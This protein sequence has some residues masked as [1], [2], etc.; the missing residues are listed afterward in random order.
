MQIVE[1]ITYK[2]V[3][4]ETIIEKWVE[5]LIEKIVEVPVEKIIEVPVI[6]TIEI[7]VFKEVIVEE[8]VFVEARSVSGWFGLEFDRIITSEEDQLR[9]DDVICQEEDASINQVWVVI[10]YVF[11][12][13][14]EDVGV[15]DEEEEEDD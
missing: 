7:P 12:L 10:D 2:E 4:Y 1:K 8:E 14:G 6:I 13:L 9:G 3:L 15:Y 11:G 5:V